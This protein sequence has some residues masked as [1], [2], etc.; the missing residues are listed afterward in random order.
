MLCVRCGREI[1]DEANY[2]PTCGSSQH[3]SVGAPWRARRLKRSRAEAKVAGVCAGFA[4]YFGVDVTLVRALWVVFSVVPG[5]IIGGL[6]AYVF[7]WLVM[8]EGDPA[9]E[10]TVSDTRLMRSNADRKIAGVCGG[11][12]EYFGVDSTPIRLFWVALSILP[13]AIVGGIL[14]YLAAWLI[15]PTAP[16]GALTP[17]QSPTGASA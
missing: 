1:S 11:L 17:S 15:M 5:A 7:T 9:P 13:G 10:A 4:E 12:A 2:C 8:P 16:T 6:L 14:I 3:T